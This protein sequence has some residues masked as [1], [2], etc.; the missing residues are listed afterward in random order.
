MTMFKHAALNIL[1]TLILLA[2]FPLAAS[3]DNYPEQ[4]IKIIVPFPPGGGTDFV[5]RIVGFKLTELTGWQVIIENRPGAG[6]NLGIEVAARAPADGYTLVMGQTD[7]MMLGPWLYSSLTY[8][9]IKSFVPVIDVSVT[10]AAISS[11]AN[12]PIKSPQDLI[13]IGKTPQGLR[14]STAGAGTLG[15][16][17]GEDFKNRTNINLLQVPYKGASPALTDVMGGQV[18]VYIGTLASQAS[19]VKSGRLRLVAV[20]TANRSAQFPD[21]QTLNESVAKGMDFSIW[22]GLFAPA[23]TSPAIVERLNKEMNRVLQSPDVIAKMAEGGVTV[24]G[25]SAQ[26]FAEFVK[27]DYANW[28]RLAKESGVK[29]D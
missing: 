18:D 11:A 28:G 13:A 20:A 1:G 27:K 14:W 22:M 7:N 24:A 8:D 6:G 12:G 3:A 29:L 23:G 19:L 26:S 25:G 10:P 17:V 16:L 9:S 4:P 5:S 2:G 15:H 21:A